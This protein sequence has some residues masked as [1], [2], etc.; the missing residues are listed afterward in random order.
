[1]Y[2]GVGGLDLAKAAK[3]FIGEGVPLEHIAV[4]NEP[5][6][7][8]VWNGD[9]CR[10]SYPKM[11]WTGAQLHSFVREHLGPTLEQQGLAAKV[12]I[13]LSTFPVNDFSGYV[14]PTLADPAALK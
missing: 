12:G 6:Q 14:K 5:N 1:M 10:N 9:S 2:K 13:F 4:Q 3:A 7:G 11:H 8:N